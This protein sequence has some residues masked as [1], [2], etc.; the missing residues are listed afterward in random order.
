M[1]YTPYYYILLLLLDPQ[2]LPLSLERTVLHARP[3]LKGR[4][5]IRSGLPVVVVGIVTMWMLM[6]LTHTRRDGGNTR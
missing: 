4:T 3:T 1:S 5:M 6:L 2:E